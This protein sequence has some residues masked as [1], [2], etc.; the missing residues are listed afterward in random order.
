MVPDHLAFRCDVDNWVVQVVRMHGRIDRNFHCL[1]FGIARDRDILV[2]VGVAGS[3]EPAREALGLGQNL[4]NFPTTL[5]EFLNFG[6]VHYNPS[7]RLGFN[8]RAA[9][10]GLEILFAEIL[11]THEPGLGVTRATQAIDCA[12]NFGPASATRVERASSFLHSPRDFSEMLDQ[13]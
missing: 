13:F 2:L 12:E 3:N 8:F 6:S 4:Y 9:M 11:G 10:L 5:N 1:G 7:L